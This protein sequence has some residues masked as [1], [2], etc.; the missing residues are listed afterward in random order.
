MT[1]EELNATIA[2]YNDYLQRMAAAAAHFCADLADSN[3]REVS[4]VLP[5]LVS[6]LSWINP[7][8]DNFV[9]M[10]HLPEEHLRVFREL[11]ANLHEALENKDNLLLHDLCEF[12]LLPLLDNIRVT[13]TLSN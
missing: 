9:K 3:Y 2:T 7:M 10:G 5:A 8:L 4:G 12:E 13:Q 1:D 6:G 11:V